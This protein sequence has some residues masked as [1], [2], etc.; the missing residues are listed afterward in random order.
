[1]AQENDSNRRTRMQKALSNE[2]TRSELS[3]FLEDERSKKEFFALMKL[4]HKIGSIEENSSN[5]RNNVEHPSPKRGFDFRI[6]LAAAASFFL[7]SAL[8]LYF[9]FFN[10][11]KNEFEIVRSVITG[12][13]EVQNA[14]ENFQIRSK[15]DSFCDYKIEGELG[16]ILRV[17]PNSE[18]HVFKKEDAFFLKLNSGIVIFTTQKKNPSAKIHA[19]VHKIRSELLGT[20]LALF[21]EENSENYKILILEGGI[22]VKTS[23]SG[24]RKSQDVFSGYSVFESENSADPKNESELKFEKTETK[25]QTRYFNLSE[26]SKRLL[27]DKD[28]K[29]DSETIEYI[30]KEIQV[31]SGFIN[32][33]YKI[34]LKNRKSYI[35]TVEEKEN[36]YI[37]TDEKGDRI[38]IDKKE[39]IEL[40]LIP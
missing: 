13:C 11:T 10:E 34:T 22:R 19:E 20:T 16:L 37:L 39:I 28:S 8:A 32:P 23:S 24:Q 7:I 18:F 33:T 29:H 21:S 5:E 30:K 31:D 38:D 1:M 17:L 27:N 12:T 14:K 3:E 36:S 4:K 2:M 9:R 25:E 26:N 35:G 6:G 40:E 15:A